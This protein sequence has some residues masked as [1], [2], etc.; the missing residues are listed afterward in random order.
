M[1][2]QKEKCPNGAECALV[3]LSGGIDSAVSFYWALSRGWDVRTIEFEYYQRPQR[4]RAAC[5]KLREWV[6]VEAPI[7]VPLGFIR[8]VVD[9]AEGELANDFLQQAPQGYIPSRNLIFYS[10][11]AY[12]AEILGARYI[13]GGHNRSDSEDFPDAGANFFSRMNELLKASMWGHAKVRTEILLPLMTLGKAEVVRLGEKLKVPFELT[14]SCY[15]NAEDP[16]GA[17]NS[18]SER[19]EAFLEAGVSDP[20]VV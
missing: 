17:C 15:H 2:D 13:I 6:G 20:L 19:M 4:E 3:L 11:A 18:C 10:L 16:C 5:R 7:I 9:L 1:P 14:W 12:H 8:E